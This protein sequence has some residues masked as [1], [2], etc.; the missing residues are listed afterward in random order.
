MIKKSVLYYD[1]G[2]NYWVLVSVDEQR[3]YSRFKSVLLRLAER[4][5]LNVLELTI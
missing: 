2:I 5:N 3:T 4:D 1:A